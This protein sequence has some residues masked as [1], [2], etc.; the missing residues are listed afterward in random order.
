MAAFLIAVLFV[1]S[2]F[3]WVEAIV[4]LVVALAI[5]PQLLSRR[6]FSRVPPLLAVLGAAAT[7]TAIQLIPMPGAMLDWLQPIG[8]SLRDEGAAL[9]HTSP[10]QGLTLDAPGSL[11]ALC[12]FVVLLGIAWL[13]LR[14]SVT[15]TGRYRVLVAVAAVCGVTAI[16]TGIHE[17]VG[18]TQLYGLY[19]P[20][21]GQPTVLGPLLNTNHLGCLMAVGVMAS[22][23]LAFYQTQAT[24]LR[25]GWMGVVTACGAVAVATQSRG[26]TLAL[27][28]G[29]LV[30][31]GVLVAQR[32]FG[33]ERRT[34]PGLVTTVPVAVVAISAIVVIV[35]ASAGGVSQELARTT[36]EEVQAPQSKFAI[37][38]AS[39]DLIDESPWVGVGRGAF[40]PAITHTHPAAA[41]ASFSHVEN[42]YIQAIVDW[43]IPGA[44][45]LAIGLAWIV[46]RGARRW[47][48]G[49]IAA[50]AI[51]GV[52]VI[53]MQSIVDFGIQLLGLAIPLTLM[54]AVLTYVPLREAEAKRK[55]VAVGARTTQLVGLCVA[56]L[57]LF[58]SVTTTVAEDHDALRGHNNLQLEDL[59]ESIERHPMDYYGYAL[60]AQVLYRERDRRAVTLLNHA[61]RLHPSHPGLHHI[62]ARALVQNDR[63]DQAAI[64]FAHAL[65][66][67]NAVQPMLAEIVKSLPPKLA[68]AAIPIDIADFDGVVRT[69]PDLSGSSE[70]AILWLTRI[71]EAKPGDMRACDWLYSYATR[72][73]NVRAAQEASSK[74]VEQ[75]LDHESRLALASMLLGEQRWAEAARTVHDVETWQG[76]IDLRARGWLIACDVEIGRARWDEAKRCLRKLDVSGLVAPDARTQV[77]TRLEKIEEQL[78]A[79]A[80]K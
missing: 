65:R 55:L 77:T 56:A 23:G 29:A 52:A 37:W 31:G 54:V 11:R 20:R 41:F 21:L 5:A 27:I 48:D 32:L 26:A 33:T 15:H 73:K 17:L 12:F 45:L 8:S 13:A 51:G 64:E 39:T 47:H 57:L 34:R 36:F 18:A 14:M 46:V 72:D 4:A 6:V 74:C 71:V 50:G 44:C 53:A 60:A 19:G 2:A 69:L 16:V 9:A 10:W 70:I 62:A 79:Q 76:R 80:P 43:G 25:I 1:G 35:Y 40:E 66:G 67:T 22:L 68:A 3:R 30:T 28:V 61:L 49:P 59:Q 58:T 63:L 38:R 24:W 7:L 78:R 42:E 75:A